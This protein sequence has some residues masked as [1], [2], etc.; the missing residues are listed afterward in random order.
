M[1][2]FRTR[3]LLMLSLLAL[4]IGSAPAVRSGEAPDPPEKLPDLGIIPDIEIDTRGVDAEGKP[5]SP[6]D[7]EENEE[8]DLSPAAEAERRAEHLLRRGELHGARVAYSEALE[9]S[10]AAGRDATGGAADIHWAEAEFYLDRAFALATATGHAKA[11]LGTLRALNGIAGNPVFASR[12]SWCQARLAWRSGDVPAARDRADRLGLIREWLLLGP[13]DNERGRHFDVPTPVESQPIDFAAPHAGLK[14]E[15][16]WRPVRTTHPLGYVPLDA[17]FY[18]R[19]EC[20]A[21]AACA[22]RAAADTPAALRLGSSDM[23]AAWLN[24]REIHRFRGQRMAHL[25]Q[26]AV[27]CQL[28]A[29]WNLLLLKLGQAKGEWGFYARFTALDGTP[30]APIHCR[31]DPKQLATLEVTW[32]GE[33]DE[34]TDAAAVPPPPLDEAAEPAPQEHP[35]PTLAGGALTVLPRRLRQDP[36]DARTHYHLGWLLMHRQ[37]LSVTDRRAL[38]HL[39]RATKAAPDR[40]TYALAFA[41]AARPHGQHEADRDENARRLVLEQAIERGQREVTARVRLAE[42]YLYSMHNLEK[43][44]A[45]AEAAIRHNPLA[46][47]A[48]VLRFDLE[49]AR[50]WDALANRTLRRLL[51]RHPSAPSVLLRAGSKALTRGDH[52][53]A[54]AHY[55][56]LLQRDGT[57][58][59]A[60][61]GV[62]EALLRQGQLNRLVDRLRRL[63]EIRPYAREL[64]LQLFDTYIR[65]GSH[66]NARRANQAL[67]ELCPRDPEVLERRGDALQWLGREAEAR[68]AWSRAL[69]IEPNL[70]PLKHRL[71]RQRREREPLGTTI[72]DLRI[73]AAQHRDYPVRR[74]D[75]RLYLLYENAHRLQPSGRHSHRVHYVV[76]LLDAEAADDFDRV[77]LPYDG[78]RQRC[79]LLS[80][81]VL[82]IDGRI[83]TPRVADRASGS[84][85]A[86]KLLHFAPV[87]PG[88]TIEVDYRLDDTRAGFFGDYFGEVFYLRQYYPVISARY[89]LA[90]P[91]NRTLYVHTSAAVP[92]ARSPAP[93]PDGWQ[94]RSWEMKGLS[95]I[96][97]EPYMPPRAELSPYIQVSTFADWNELGRWYWHLIKDQYTMTDDIRR[98]VRLLTAGRRSP[99]DKLDAIYRW[100]TQE[101]RNTAWEFGV[102]GYKPYQVGNIFQ[103]RFGDCKDK[104]ALIQVM[105]REIGLDARPVLLYALDESG[106]RVGRG[107]EDLALPILGHFNHAITQ[108]RIGARTLW[109]DGTVQHRGIAGYPATDAGAQTAII[110][111]D[112]A[113][114]EP[115]PPHTAA[116]QQWREEATLTLADDGSALLEQDISGHGVVATHMRAYFHSDHPPSRIL[117]ALAS[118]RL[119]A[120]TVEEAAVRE[121]DNL[122]L[123]QVTVAGK[124]VLHDWVEKTPKGM[125]FLLPAAWLR[126][127]GVGAPLPLRLSSLAQHSSRAHDL[128][129]PRPFRIETRTTISLPTGYR[130]AS[131]PPDVAES[132]PFGQ[133]KAR[134]EQQGTAV[135]L[136]RVIALEKTRIRR[137]AYPAFRRFCHLA[138]EVDATPLVLEKTP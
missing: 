107:Q 92:A 33:D 98:Q 130:L 99:V 137:E 133:V 8:E 37:G 51:R 20:Q 19:N 127:E 14:G 21:Y 87:Q 27:P 1:T 61:D 126:S 64:H 3:G 24:G 90:W 11:L 112:G 31:A 70:V 95:R 102:H 43:A 53:A 67:L 73:F 77:V 44:E 116:D 23:I 72:P 13:F 34:P 63:L 114:L 86:Y 57:H 15:V 88:D 131:L 42:Y 136:H 36:Y 39:V 65:L 7:E 119:G 83:E 123:D 35:A 91:A 68:D 58:P 25:D 38:R 32:P 50:G 120:V 17:F 121:A 12:L 85:D 138:D 104:A 22:V 46:L 122:W 47:D 106:S 56:R 80:T 30:L 28:R 101:I 55:E 134:Y 62:Y 52:A 128:L 29:G 103:R 26:D 16:R 115:L 113:T 78:N 100:V 111:P 48:Q 60:A 10:V 59:Q 54:A 45:L 118:R 82:R 2:R 129:L 108:V 66:E 125:Q 5:L 41:E 117:H 89:S 71:A 110:L 4:A 74:G 6:P 84:S 132:H 79:T 40:V 81:R 18:P 94:Q 105:A 96:E 135:T 76:R 93:T 9:A 75:S 124:M 49:R 69:A 97:I 109:L